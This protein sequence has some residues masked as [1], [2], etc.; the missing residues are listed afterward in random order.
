V[1]GQDLNW[2]WDNWFFSHNYI[3]LAIKSVEKTSAGYTVLINNIGGMAA[4]VNL[5]IKYADGSTASLHETPLIWQADQ[6]LA[7]VDIPSEKNIQSL[8][9]DGGIFMDADPSNNKWKP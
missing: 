4:P 1:S 8:V 5:L 3:D 2:F 6:R 7:R 9:L